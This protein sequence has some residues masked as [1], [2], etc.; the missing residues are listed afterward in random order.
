MIV[1]KSLQ[2][3]LQLYRPI[4]NRTLPKSAIKPS[5][6]L[7]Y[8][9]FSLQYD[10]NTKFTNYWLR[11]KRRN[12]PLRGKR[13]LSKIRDFSFVKQ[14][15]IFLRKEKLYCK[16]VYVEER[17]DLYPDPEKSTGLDINTKTLAT[18]DNKFYSTKQ[19]LQRKLEHKKNRMPNRNAVNFTKD[20]VHKLTTQIVSDLIQK[21]QEVLVLEDLNGLRQS[22][23]KKKGTS[24]GKHVNYLINNCLPYG[25]FSDFLEYKCRDHGIK[26]VNVNPQNTSK[27]CSF[28]NS[29]DTSRPKQTDFICNSCGFQLHADLNAARNIRLRYISPNGLIVNPTTYSASKL[30]VGSC[31]L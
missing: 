21:G 15:Q 10:E 2:N 28:C 16:I 22:A 11:I 20:F 12:F 29:L 23:S 3:F 4:K 1:E 14:I 7:D 26:C 31:P 19:L 17:P 6:I 9:N 13:I 25:M 27:M 30:A 18:S 24:K 8:Q 5:I